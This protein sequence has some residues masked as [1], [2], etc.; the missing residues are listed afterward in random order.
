[1]TG[2]PL[3]LLVYLTTPPPMSVPNLAPALAIRLSVSIH[4]VVKLIGAYHAHLEGL[5]RVD[6]ASWSLGGKR[7]SRATFALAMKIVTSG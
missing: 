1:M 5:H 7:R 6:V 3:V 4:Q 2:P